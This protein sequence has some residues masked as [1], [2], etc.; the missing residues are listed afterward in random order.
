MQSFHL[1]FSTILVAVY[2]SSG[3][4]A[5]Q[6]V[7]AQSTSE[8]LAFFEKKIR[9]VL[10]ES[11]FRCHGARRQRGDVRLDTRAGVL[12]GSVVV[13]GHPEKSKLV[14]VLDHTGKIKMP[15][16]GQ[17][18]ANVIAD[19]KAWVEMGAPW[20][21]DAAKATNTHDHHWAF[22]KVTRP[23]LPDVKE[24]EWVRNA[25]D[26]FVLAKLE[27][28][29]MKHAPRADKRSLLRRV[30]YG[31]IGL[32]PT[33]KEV[34]DFLA[35]GSPHALANVVDRLLASP[36]YGERWGRYWLDIAR[37][38]DTKGYVFQQER[39]YPFSYTYRDYV[40]RAFNEDVPYDKFLREQIAADRLLAA[41]PK[42]DKQALAAM[43][44]LTVGR[45][46]RNNVHDIIDD[47]ID[48]VSRGLLGLT[49][50]CA[51]CHDHKYDPIP[52]E[53][54]YSLYGVFA[55]S[56]EPKILPI[57]VKT[58]GNPA[59]LP[60]QEG[61]AKRQKDLDERLDDAYVNAVT[62][63]R[64]N[65]ADYLLEARNVSKRA[66]DQ[67]IPLLSLKQPHAGM[68]NRWRALVTRLRNKPHSILAP[69]VALAELPDGKFRN[70]S[71][72]LI[73]EIVSRKAPRF[74][75]NVVIAKAFQGPP[76]KSLREVAAR[77]DRVFKSVLL[78]KKR[79]DAE[80]V[81]YKFLVEK[82]PC[83]IPR[84]QTESFATR[85][86]RNQLRGLRREIDRY[87][88]SS[89]NSPPRAMI[90]RDN[91]QPFNPY[92]F[93]RGKPGNRGPNIPR[94]FLEVLEGKGR[95]PFQRGSGRLELANKIAT[96]DNPLTAR[97][98]VN[99]VWMHHFGK[100][101]VDTPDDFGLRCAPPV[102][103]ELL[104]YL[105]W[106]F[107]ENDW[108]LKKLH[109]LI[110]L[111][112]TYQ[113]ACVHNTNYATDD[114]DNRYLW[115]MNRR[116]LDFEAMRDSLLF[117]AGRLD[118]KMGGRSVDITK[119]PSP[120]RRTVYAFI[121]RQNL[122]GLFRTFDLASPD[123]TTAQRH[124]TTV[125]QQALFLMNNPFLTRQ[126]KALLALQG[127][128]AADT[129]SA[130]I[131]KLYRQIFGRDP[132]SDELKLGRGFVESVP[133]SQRPMAWEHYAQALL[134]SNE[135]IFV[136]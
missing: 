60:F 108:S 27:S 135:F 125:P 21:E 88:A 81:V 20:P 69:W 57:I 71:P 14:R 39:R 129:P 112:N 75:G 91:P 115:K 89:P 34:D 92:V 26:G 126:A 80:D 106:R 40:I 48:V 107:M 121:D 105:A 5:G 117:V 68:V 24:R 35:D 86:V 127:I 102:Q 1:R 118:L 84:S 59:L 85:A 133:A 62:K 128:Q 97:V 79:T 87:K 37:Y 17:L 28:K 16:N 53:D 29:G 61:L 44:F 42:Y 52:T 3:A 9:P 12:T 83:N 103:R 15:P 119:A 99:R 109:R 18:P 77:Y 8:R 96:K 38:A 19:M 130:K 131:P 73:Q 134:L 122:P 111:S 46:F 22:Q 76:P 65:V 51:R 49:V 116:R 74:R 54:Y 41:N 25:I 31:L 47:R 114:P 124:A 30:H 6:S 56:S 110:V 7:N 70:E 33:A 95:R 58:E 4:F 45:R 11:C 43:G 132:G 64:L 104:D 120:P 63:F 55:S 123:A 101:L 98:M 136:D 82:A 36:R 50:S 93:R 78:K 23:E 67:R 72:K 90:L 10:A 32:P 100:P 13:P 66:H 113:Q 94:Q 2:V